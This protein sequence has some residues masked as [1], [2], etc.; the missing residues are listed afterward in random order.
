MPSA[1]EQYTKDLDAALRGVMQKLMDDL[2]AVRGN[3]PSVDLVQDIMVNVYDQALAIKQLGSLSVFPPRGIQISLWDKTSVAPVLKAIE[4]A[5]IGLS[6]SNDGQNII[7]TL[8]TLHDERR[9]EL[10]KLAKK[11][12]ESARIQVRTRRDDAMKKIKEAEAGKAM[13]EDEAFKT[14]EKIQKIVD[15]MNKNIESA[16]GAKIAELGEK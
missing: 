2:R 5:K 8:S 1:G 14:K 7:A 15:D 9:D 13:S 11:M 6:V 12:S 4:D 10:T 16:V 3:R